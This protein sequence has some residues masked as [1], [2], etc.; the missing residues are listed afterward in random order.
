MLEYKQLRVVGAEGRG[1]ATDRA[2]NLAGA[3]FLEASVLDS[4]YTRAQLNKQ[5]VNTFK[6]YGS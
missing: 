4:T 6:F 5:W 1:V 2:D 3:P